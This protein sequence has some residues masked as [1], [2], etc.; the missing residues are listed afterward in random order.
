MRR[1]PQVIEQTESQEEIES[2]I[3]RYFK[4]YTIPNYHDVKKNAKQQ[5]ITCIRNPDSSNEA[6]YPNRL[7]MISDREE[8]NGRVLRG[9]IDT[10][11]PEQAGNIA[12][13]KNNTAHKNA[14]ARQ[15]F[16]KNVIGRENRH[17]KIPTKI[18][19]YRYYTPTA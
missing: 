16:V 2:R 19:K 4:R 7:K 12:A 8:D 14:T 10:N 13:P 1:N 18:I 17:P 6:E 5:R 3:Q 11:I 9:T 15:I